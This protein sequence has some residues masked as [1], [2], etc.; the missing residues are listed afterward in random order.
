[1]L[2]IGASP[3]NRFTEQHDIFFSIGKQLQDLVPAIQ[4]FWADAYPKIHIDAWRIVNNVNGF[5]IRIVERDPGSAVQHDSAHRLFFMNLG[6]YKKNEFDEFHY[7]MVIAAA[8]K[9][10]AV[11]QAKQTAF[12]KHIGFK[13]ATSHIDDKYGVDVDDFYEIRDILSP[14]L[15]NR[16]SIEL[17]PE[18]DLPEDEINLGYFKL[19]KLDKL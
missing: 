13:G 10:E 4:N 11:Q 2:L 12:Y 19:D 8:D 7:R 1:M 14:D 3:K 5:K 15:T 18:P 9:G 6:G 16:F 17:T